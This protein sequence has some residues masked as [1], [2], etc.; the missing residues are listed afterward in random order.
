MRDKNFI[1]NITSKDFKISQ[2][3][4]NELIA[5][6]T[7][8]LFE[9]L[10]ASSEF[11][12]P[13]I[14]NR[15]VK[16]F[17]DLIK[18]ENLETVFEFSKIY[19]Y[20]F[21]DIVVSSWLKFANEDLTDRILELFEKGTVEQK[22]Y[23]AKYFSK[24]NDSLALENLKKYAL[25]DYEPLRLNCALALC[26]FQEEE[27]TETAKR[28]IKSKDDKN[29]DEFKKLNAFLFLIAYDSFNK[30][31][32][33]KYIIKNAQK[34][35]FLINIISY[36]KNY[37]SFETLKNNLNKKELQNIFAILIDNYP[38]NITLD[39]IIDYEIFEFVK[40]LDSESSKEESNDQFGKNLLILTKIK[41]SEYLE[42]EI[43]SFDLDKETKKEMENI[44]GFLSKYN[45][46]LNDADSIINE[47]E[48]YSTNQIQ[49]EI[50]INIIKELNLINVFDKLAQ[51]L[52]DLINENKLN[53]ILLSKTAFILKDFNKTHLINKNNIENIENENVKALVLS[54]L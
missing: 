24:I 46:T 23:C 8:L 19:S 25:C 37:Y 50:M 2:N 42:N 6:K 26:A 5:S 44:V 3:S 13:F 7:T 45:K 43:Y 32:T 10:C 4:I 21:E 17:V 38:E 35:P 36:L 39:T 54:L 27:T 52:A 14:K 41:F 11:I 16:N 48:T 33:I 29:I 40:F 30:N 18:I 20:D 53:Y 28:I 31:N 22:S 47:L 9:K 12:F 34:S 51:F 1:K 15:I 49:F